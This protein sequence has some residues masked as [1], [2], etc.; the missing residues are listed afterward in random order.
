MS[1]IVNPRKPVAP[2]VVCILRTRLH[3]YTPT[4]ARDGPVQIL[5]H[6]RSFLQTDAFAGH[7]GIY[8]V[9]WVAEVACRAHARCSRR[10]CQPVS[11]D[12]QE[13]PSVL[14]RPARG[15]R[16]T[17]KVTFGPRTISRERDIP[18]PTA[19]SDARACSS[20]RLGVAGRILS[21]TSR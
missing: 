13:T 18:A 10:A 7:D 3:S 19:G 1:L 15:P 11:T 9:G 6:Y 21:G 14:P 20:C 17:H 16:R 4:H 8:A 2:A 5:G 12:H